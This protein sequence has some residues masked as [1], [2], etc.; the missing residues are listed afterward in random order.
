MKKLTSLLTLAVVAVLLSGCSMKGSSGTSTLSIPL[1]AISSSDRSMAQGM[2]ERAVGNCTSN[3]NSND[4]PPA[5]W[6]GFNC[7]GVE[8]SGQGISRDPQF[9]CTGTEDQAVHILGGLIPAGAGSIDL[10][11]PSGP[12]RLVRL[13]GVKTSSGVGCP[14]VNTFLKT[15]SVNDSIGSPFLLAETYTDIFDD[16]AVSM[17]VSYDPSNPQQLFPN[18]N[19]G[20]NNSSGPPS[21]LDVISSMNTVIAGQ[22]TSFNVY[23]VDN[24]D[25]QATLSAAADVT[26]GSSS[27]TVTFFNDPACTVQ[28]ST[29]SVP[30]SGDGLF[31]FKATQAGND[32]ISALMSSP[33][34]G[35][36]TASLVVS[37]GTA[38]KLVFVNPT[39]LS[40]ST[41]VG[42]AFANPQVEFQDAYSNVVTGISPTAITLSA[43]STAACSTL[44]SSQP[45]SNVEDSINGISTFSSLTFIT[46]IPF[47]YMGA[48]A[49][50]VTSACTGTSLQIAPNAN[51][52]NS[53]YTFTS[54]TAITAQTPTVQGGTV[55][56]CTVTPTLPSGLS[57]SGSDCTISGTPASPSTDTAYTVSITV[58]SE[59]SVSITIHITVN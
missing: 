57:L 17:T 59:N 4:C 33:N 3:P 35:N 52:P 34:L 16:T 43:Y 47:A 9:S 7:F 48:S 44:S 51:Y 13:F 22:C 36:A 39:S 31:Y 41:L 28:I 20:N 37:A 8:V 11:V 55:S 12:A 49:T 24:N 40:G 25:N 30:P 32:S 5:T 46:E 56:S 29:G 10:N 2:T 21:Q 19:N 38:T 42:D 6:Q 18:C 26:F 15:N 54:G 50:G 53:S 1:P 14:D 45:V 23:A 58:N 27:G